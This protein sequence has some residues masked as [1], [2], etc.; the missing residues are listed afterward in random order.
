MFYNK[1]EEVIRIFKHVPEQPPQIN[2]LHYIRKIKQYFI[3]IN[4][5]RN[6]INSPHFFYTFEKKYTIS[7]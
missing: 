1:T 2:K 3:F 7:I 5:R 4:H 6:E